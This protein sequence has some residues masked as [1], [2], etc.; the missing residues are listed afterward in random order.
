MYP[1]MFSV[2]R[3][4]RPPA[5][6]WSFICRPAGVS[7]AL[8]SA[9]RP[10]KPRRRLQTLLL[11]FIFLF[12]S[13][14]E[15][16]LGLVKTFACVRL[17][18]LLSVCV[19]DCEA[20]SIWWLCCW[21]RGCQIIT[22]RLAAAKRRKRFAVVQVTFNYGDKREIQLEKQ[23]H[24]SSCRLCRSVNHTVF[25]SVCMHI[26]LYITT[27]YTVRRISVQTDRMAFCRLLNI[28]EV[29]LNE[30]SPGHRMH[31]E[32]IVVIIWG[33]NYIQTWSDCSEL[34]CKLERFGDLGLICLVCWSADPVVRPL[35]GP[36][37]Q[38]YVRLWG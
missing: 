34:F 1:N 2:S 12:A 33:G 16:K 24:L 23:L 5:H 37:E 32:V 18:V 35:N 4:V 14:T 36:W 21:F 31:A 6:I 10:T 26:T 27:R 38:R 19:I 15:Q 7:S 22:R 8:Q 25:L 28:H 3:P 17:F 20:A 29:L 11:V 30:S 9:L 13:V